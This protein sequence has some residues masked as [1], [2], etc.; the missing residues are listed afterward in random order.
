MIPSGHNQPETSGPPLV[1]QR[2]RLKN[3]P[4]FN[5]GALAPSYT[6]PGPRRAPAWKNDQGRKRI[7]WEFGDIA[8]FHENTSIYDAMADGLGVSLDGDSSDRP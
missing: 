1:R 7:V 6:A 8:T 5:P 4:A 2:T 3:L